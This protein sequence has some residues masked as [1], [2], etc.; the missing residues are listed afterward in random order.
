MN[1]KMKALFKKRSTG[2]VASYQHVTMALVALSLLI[3]L[4][5]CS[6]VSGKNG[7]AS[8]RPTDEY[9]ARTVRKAAPQSA[10][11]ANEPKP[12][13]A[14]AEQPPIKSSEKVA[15]QSTS[16]AL[17]QNATPKK[18]ASLPSSKSQPKTKT[19]TKTVKLKQKVPS[20][21]ESADSSVLAAP[22]SKAS[23]I[24]TSAEKPLHQS[25]TQL[26]KG[27]A[28]PLP[29]KVSSDV[30]KEGILLASLDQ[31]PILIDK[32]WT[33]DR[34]ND[35][36]N[37]CALSY[38]RL[39]I[40]D[41]QGESP[42]DVVIKKDSVIV[43]T[44]SNIDLG[45]EGTGVTVDTNS[46]ISIEEL[47]NE[48]SIQFKQSHKKLVEEMERGEVARVTLGFWPTW[49]ITQTYSVSFEVGNF[50]SGHQALMACVE[51]EKELK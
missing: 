17:A 37:S 46:Q 48:T 21:V 26:P 7:S 20:S 3:T 41:G 30:P 31:L 22:V 45:Y 5:G 40:E 44:G 34:N 28:E 8:A 38:R 10:T 18:G 39:L 47:L 43:N 33:L 9:Q 29:A 16:S 1:N 24:E 51:L 35:S 23:P 42:V 49:P 50:S 6:S 2:R 19:K 32:N 15:V 25:E 36:L 11:A 14:P 12:V 13:G 4:N 27:S